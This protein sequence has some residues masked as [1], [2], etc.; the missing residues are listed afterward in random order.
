MTAGGPGGGVGSAAGAAVPGPVPAAGQAP[1]PSPDTTSGSAREGDAA[2]A[3]GGADPTADPPRV[4]DV[5]YLPQ[6]E[7]LCG[8]AAAA[9]VM[10]YWGA[11]RVRPDGFAHLVEDVRGGIRSD[12]LVADLR[13]RGWRAHA[14]SGRVSDL[15]RHVERG[16]PATVLLEAGPDR[17]H[18]VVVVAVPEG[19]VLYHDPADAPFQSMGRDEFMRRWRAADR[20]TLLLLPPEGR[21]RDGKAGSA[22]A[23]PDAVDPAD[24][25]DTTAAGDGAARGPGAR[26]A[27]PCAAAVRRAVE[28]AVDGQEAAAD[29][30]L[31]AA[32]ARCPGSPAPHRELAGLRFRQQRW[33]EASRQAQKA[34]AAAPADSQTAHLLGAS[35]YMRGDRAEALRAWN[36]IGRPEVASVRVY[37]LERARWEAVRPRLGLERGEVL[38]PARLA[39]ARRRAGS[40]PAF[41]RTRVR[42]RPR[43]DGRADVQVAVVERPLVFGSPLEAVVSGLASLPQ[44]ELR[45]DAAGLAGAGERW[46]GAWR[47]WDERPA[48]HLTAA[49]P[50]AFGVDGRWTVRGGWER[51]T[52]G[53]AGARRAEERTGGGLGF[54]RWASG[55]LRWEAGLALDRWAGRQAFL[56]PSASLEVR[57]AGDRAA[58]RAGAA[59]W[60]GLDDGEAFPR[61]SLQA[62][63]RPA[64]PDEGGTGGGP[65]VGWTVEL[66]AGAV[67]VAAE[68]PLSA[69][70]GAGT[71]D[72]RRR[73]LRAHPLLDDGA[74]TGEGFG[75]LLAHG[76]V[77]VRAWLFAVGP[78]RAGVG[79][80]ADAARPWGRA[81]GIGD[82]SPGNGA[83]AA[84]DGPGG[85][86][87]LLLDGGAGLRLAPG[88]GAGHLR[89]DVAG[90]LLDEAGAVSVGWRAP[91]PGW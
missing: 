17:Y 15:R 90:G 39:T 28:H 89:V 43:Q 80:F 22:E 7:A 13:G 11:G 55:S 23:G 2:V 29:S 5:P 53:A 87:G 6:T 24:P 50:R 18:Y 9:M 8:G 63:W 85:G 26:H 72:A 31:R 33:A 37:G 83:A 21:A 74:I 45:L 56:R 76:G 77:E 3:A 36:R 81:R 34:L 82:P 75:R 51:E 57:A 30:L 65:G 88:G 38:T 86:D 10:R 54:S 44:R 68:A 25:S 19:A 62:A 69:W 49:F 4:L 59:A 46:T 16:R 60:A 20:W 1:P 84:G 47:W 32:A 12:R 52:F 70:P 42:Y 48:V 27:A 61:A 73:L 35:R 79:G 78:V 66:R 40:V 64:A 14:F 67:A 41:A 58:V 91:W 71:G